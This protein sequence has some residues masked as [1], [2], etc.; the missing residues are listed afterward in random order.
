MLKAER[1]V[2]TLPEALCSVLSGEVV[3][4]LYNIE[5][6]ITGPDSEWKPG[7]RPMKYRVSRKVRARA[8]PL[9]P[10]SGITLD[11][12]PSKKPNS[13]PL[14]DWVADQMQNKRGV[15]AAV[16]VNSTCVSLSKSAACGSAEF[17]LE[18]FLANP[19]LFNED[20]TRSFHSDNR[21]FFEAN[22]LADGVPPFLPEGDAYGL[23]VSDLDSYLDAGLRVEVRKR[24]YA[25]AGEPVVFQEYNKQMSLCAKELSFLFEMAKKN[26]APCVIAA[27]YTHSTPSE[28]R[29]VDMGATPLSQV[30]ADLQTVPK[31]G[32]VTALVITTQISTFS[33][34]SLLDAIRNAPVESKRDHLIGVLQSACPSIFAVVRDMILPSDGYSMVK[35]NMTPESV[36]F[37]PKLVASESSWTLEGT[38]FM[39]VSQDYLD[40]VPKI[41]DFNAVFTTRVREASFSA[42]TSFVMHSMLLVAFAR[43]QYGP[44][45]SGVMW[46]HLLF[47]QD[48]SGF[49]K[50]A[51]SMQS[52][53]TNASAFLACL[54]ANS[55]MREK[56]DLSKAMAELV[57][58]MDFA[59]RDGVVGSDGKL[60]ASP[61]RHMFGKLVSIVSGAA[62]PDTR[63]FDTEGKESE[64][65]EVAHV[66][67]L[68]VVKQARLNRLAGL[69]E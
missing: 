20:K 55:D 57:S 59:V 24:P 60:S 26:I 50:A 66:R 43:A 33:L 21:T 40:G 8:S 5:S 16:P 23:R 68:E 67:A 13:I 39:P 38:G 12:S 54:A 17:W 14:A 69:R 47:E 28:T 51:K 63:L 36:V 41:T 44:V 42:E 45:A 64:D 58:D 2:L 61:D 11:T 62:F 34:G 7:A 32:K 25:A 37:C 46:S 9:K 22:M 31:D 3:P 56:P 4:E 30:P 65:S 48:P 52:K 6:A 15:L 27:F 19:S 18:N 1:R 29:S 49:L 10:A 35:L 53:Q